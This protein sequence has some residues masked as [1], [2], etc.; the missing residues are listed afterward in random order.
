MEN[1]PITGIRIAHFPH[2]IRGLAMVK[3]AAARANRK[4]GLLDEGIADAID[5]AAQEV[6]DGHWQGHFVVDVVQG[7]AGTSTNMNA[8]EV[9][10]NRALELMGHERGD[11]AHCHPNNH[12]NLGQSTNDA[13]PTAVRVATVLE[14]RDLADALRELEHALREK[15]EE[16]ADVLKM[17][18]TQ[19]QDAVPMTL[20]QEFGAFADTTAE[21]IPAPGG[22]R[23]APPGGEPGRHG[24][25][26]RHQRRPALPRAGGGAA[27]PHHGPRPGTRSQPGGGHARHRGLRC[28]LRSPQTHRG[29]ALQ[30][31]QRPPP[32]V[33]GSA[34]RDQ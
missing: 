21:D 27:E 5:R 2:L 13:Y 19:L 25:R 17:G 14:Q 18:R 28:L 1:F 31:V 22:G 30:D 33:V 4:L 9:I 10:A 24:H 16:F 26:N 34:M 32:A 6:I 12:V 8:N 11:Y 15:A 23:P 20:G 29:E 7:G 3:Q